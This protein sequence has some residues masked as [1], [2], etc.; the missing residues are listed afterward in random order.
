MQTI[1]IQAAAN[2]IL[3]SRV[4]GQNVTINLYD[5]HAQGLFADASADGVTL[6]TG[7]LCLDANPIIPTHYLG[8]SGNFIFVD[9]QGN[10][11][12]TYAGLGSRF[13]LVYLT[14]EEYAL[15]GE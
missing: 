11:D 6:I 9:T 1:P 7:V 8:F 5:K 2:Q 15:L 14:A 4:A 3:Q 12:P 10:S 13:Q